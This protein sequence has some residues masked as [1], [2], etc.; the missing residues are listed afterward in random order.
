MKSN[1]KNFVKNLNRRNFTNNTQRVLHT[2]LTAPGNGWVTLSRLRVPSAGA[3]VRDLRKAQ[4]GGLSVACSR[5]SEAGVR[6]ASDFVYRLNKSKIT[7]EQLRQ[8]FPE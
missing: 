1:V 7:V 4:Y 6:T 5:S 2:L 8:V 3:R